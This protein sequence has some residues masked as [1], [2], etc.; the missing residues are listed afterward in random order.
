MQNT[1]H[2]IVVVSN[3]PYPVA[4]F[5]IR[6]SAIHDAMAKSK[7]TYPSPPVAMPVFASH[8]ADLIAKETAAKTRAAGT[9]AD[10]DAARR[11]VVVDIAQLQSYV[12]KLVNADPVNADSLAQAAGMTV[13]KATYPAKPPLVAKPAFMGVMRLVAKAIKGGKTN[14]WQFSTDG[15]TTW[16]STPSSTK[17]STTIAGLQ[18]GS[19][20][21]FRHRAIT[22]MGPGDW[23][24]PITATVT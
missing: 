12:Q 16:V 24:Q 4:D 21:S 10:R 13:R 5:I 19:L 3:L 22:K 9:V 8:I 1:P 18:V 20:V 17:A 7:T 14:E 2:K 15:G 11:V 6:A 23:G